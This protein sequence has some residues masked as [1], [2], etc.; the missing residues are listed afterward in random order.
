M[1]TGFLEDG[2]EVLIS[3]ERFRT[4]SLTLDNE[5]EPFKFALVLTEEIKNAITERCNND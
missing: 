2:T 4:L 5:E 1:Q 3:N